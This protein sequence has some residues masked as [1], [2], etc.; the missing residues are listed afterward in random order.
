MKY[1]EIKEKME[2]P[3]SLE[4]DELEEMY[5]TIR[6]LSYDAENGQENEL[7][8]F[9]SEITTYGNTRIGISIHSEPGEM[10]KKIRDLL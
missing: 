4:H 9:L 7:T 3:E 10:K 6:E 1:Q 2:L 8:P 5:N